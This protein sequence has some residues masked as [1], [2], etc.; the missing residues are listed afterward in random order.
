MLDFARNVYTGQSF[1]DDG[2]R[3][4]TDSLSIDNVIEKYDIW[5]TFKFKSDDKN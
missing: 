1:S 4:L 3:G 5:T 2:D